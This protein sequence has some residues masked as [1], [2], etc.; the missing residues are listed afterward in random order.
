MSKTRQQ[1]TNIC[2]GFIIF[3]IISSFI[4]NTLI[5]LIMPQKVGLDSRVRTVIYDPNNVV[6]IDTVIGLATHI[7]LDAQERYITHVFGDAQAYAFFVERN[8]LFIKP[9][10][11]EAHTN[12]IVITN[13]RHYSFK[14]TF[15]P[16]MTTSKA[17]YQL[18]FIYPDQDQANSQTID[19]KADLERNWFMP[20]DQVNLNYTMSGDLEIAP[21][22]V[23]DHNGFTYFK[24][25]NHQDIPA[26]Y[27]IDGAGQES[28]VNHH[29][30]E[31]NSPIMC[32]HKINARWIL[33]LGDQALAIF[34]EKM[35]PPQLTKVSGTA[36][37]TIYRRT[38]EPQKND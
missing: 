15:H 23:W 37:P 36:S 7:V 33:R 9:C 5:A 29:T 2:S 4:P 19:K 26:I 30:S 13:L 14:L 34:N 21:I 31:T 17:I 11:E 6:H 18:R 20:L 27:M 22:N 12:L 16:T 1:R 24:F 32:F 10:A 25:S 38:K 28:I 8:H 3:S 35:E